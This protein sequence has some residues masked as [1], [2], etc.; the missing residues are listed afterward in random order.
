MSGP[1]IQSAMSETEEEYW[2]KLEAE[3]ARAIIWFAIL[4]II[5]AVR[6]SLHD[7]EFWN[8]PCNSPCL[9]ITTYLVPLFTNWIWLWIGYAACMIV[10]FSE[11]WFDRFGWGRTV[12]EIARR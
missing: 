3:K 12:R 8:F 2:R 5:A 10:Y 11:D 7:D 1:S 6:I 4:A 9:H